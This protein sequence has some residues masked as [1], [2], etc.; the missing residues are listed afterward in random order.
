[1]AAPGLPWY[2][3]GKR[4]GSNGME[5]M[6]DQRQGFPKGVSGNPAGRMSRAACAARIEAKARELA[7]EFGGYDAV[8][9]VD[10]VLLTQAATLLLRRPKSA[11]D[12]VRLG[13]GILR[14]LATLQRKYLT[15][16]DVR[17]RLDRRWQAQ[18]RGGGVSDYLRDDGEAA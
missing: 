6:P 2:L 17:T 10:R 9:P 15:R 12:S 5:Q 13:N 8:S 7:V 1:M 14:A 4:Q 18:A 11:E 3:R 16:S